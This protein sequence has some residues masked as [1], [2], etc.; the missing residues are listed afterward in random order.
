[1]SK[2]QPGSGYAIDSGFYGQSDLDSVPK[3]ALNLSRGCGNPTGFA[4]LKTGEVVVDFGCGGGIDVVL[5]SI[6]VGETGCVF[7]VDFTP[8]MIER[9]KQSVIDAG[10]H[11]R[12][13]ELLVADLTKTQLADCF[14]DVIISNCVINLCPDKDAVYKEAFRLLKTGGRLAISDI[15]FTKGIDSQ[16]HQRFQSTWSGCLGGAISEEDYWQTVKSS[17]F[18]KIKIVAKQNL[19]PEELEAMACCPGDKFTPPPSEEDR[20]LV[21][22]KV[23]SVKFTALKKLE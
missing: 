6:K 12:N 21:E 23:A 7:G 11:E 1:M 20:L 14:A 13:I 19:T 3:S 9:A 18:T 10:F 17:G 16:L 2:R 4:K 5:T 15:V 8:Q 22:G